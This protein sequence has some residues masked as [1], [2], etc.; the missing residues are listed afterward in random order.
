[1]TFDRAYAI[2]R[3]LSIDDQHRLLETLQAE[4]QP[5]DEWALQGPQLAFM[6]QHHDEIERAYQ[7]GEMAALGQIAASEEYRAVFGDMPWDEAYDRYEETWWVDDDD[8][9]RSTL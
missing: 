6:I 4:L 5:A 8:F 1:M 9:F 7:A 2:I 3:Q